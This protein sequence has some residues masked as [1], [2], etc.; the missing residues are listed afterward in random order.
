MSPQRKCGCARQ[1][2]RSACRAEPSSLPRPSALLLRAGL[3]GA[4]PKAGGGRAAQLVFLPR[5]FK[6]RDYYFLPSRTLIDG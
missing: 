2:D 1:P 3:P 6:L 4:W 5:V